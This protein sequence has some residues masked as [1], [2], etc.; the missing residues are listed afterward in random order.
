MEF[1][2][3][4]NEAV[5]LVF[6]MVSSASPDSFVSGETVTDTAYYY[7]GTWNTLAIT[8]TV[9]EIGTTG[10]YQLSMAQGEMNYDLIMI[11]LT[12]TNSADSALIIRTYAVDVDDL[13][14]STTPANTLDVTATGAAGIDWGNVENQGTSVDLSATAINLADTATTVT[15]GVTVTTN[16]DKT[17]YSLTQSFP[18]NFSSLAIDGTGQVTV[19]TNNDKTGYSL[20]QTF[21]ANFADLAIT[22]STGLVSVGTNNDKTGYSIS[23]TITTLDG[24]NNFDPTT[25]TVANVTTVG[26]VSGAVGSVT[27]NVGGNVTGSV[28]SISGVTF[29]TNFGDLA[30]TV[31]TGYVTAGTV[32]DKTGY[33]LTQSFPANFADLSITASTGLVD[34]N[35]KTGYS[36]SGTKTTLDDLND[37][38]TAQV[39]AEVVDVIS[40]DARPEPGQGAPAANASLGTKVDHLYKSLRNKKTATSS[41]ISIYND[42]GDTVDQKRSINDDGTTYTEDEIVTGP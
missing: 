13:V 25:D 5:E 33:S 3:K 18:T 4:K 38:T 17:G 19:G 41:T 6:P 28:G 20:T 7:N 12:S 2:L 22:A 27:G 15:N 14:R 10:M 34:V 42:A 30:I 21:P 9:T 31:T 40:T 23:G 35:D 26:S 11:K 37:I 36:I 24:L 29:P 39:N 1:H 32:I 16:N 8:D